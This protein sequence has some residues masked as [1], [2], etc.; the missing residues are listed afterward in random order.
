MLFCNHKKQ[1]CFFNSMEENNKIYELLKD[2]DLV[3]KERKIIL[4]GSSVVIGILLGFTLNYFWVMDIF[5]L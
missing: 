3:V 2:Y 5:G 4:F 1:V